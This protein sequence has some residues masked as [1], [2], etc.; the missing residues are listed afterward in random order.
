MSHIKL[1]PISFNKCHPSSHAN[2]RYLSIPEKCQRLKELHHQSRITKQK[3]T[4]LRARIEAL[5]SIRAVTVDSSLVEELREIVAEQSPAV[6]QCHPSGSFAQIFWENQ[7][8]AMALKDSR[9]M[10]WDPLTI[11]WCLYLRHVCGNGCE[12]LRES[13]IIKLPSQ[14]TL[15][16]YTYFTKTTVGFSDD[17]DE[18]LKVAAKVDSCEEREKYVVIVM[19]E[20]HIKEDVVYDKHTGKIT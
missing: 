3:I 17:V 5:T 11:R 14:R 19:D 6:N 18:Q 16:D 4:H 1:T 8:H 12:F 9:S 7:K 20:M 10:K 15:R 2:Y 13:G